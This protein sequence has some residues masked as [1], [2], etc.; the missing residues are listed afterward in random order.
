M[1][2]S[3]GDPKIVR[4]EKKPPG[5]VVEAAFCSVT[6]FLIKIYSDE[7]YEAISY[8]TVLIPMMIYFVLSIMY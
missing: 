8:V 3:V 2:Q 6:L 4:K 7:M 5:F 1:Y